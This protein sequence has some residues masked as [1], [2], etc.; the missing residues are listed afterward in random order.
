MKRFF[1]VASLLSPLLLSLNLSAC[2][3]SVGSEPELSA[4]RPTISPVDPVNPIPDPEKDP[5]A[6]DS[7]TPPV[8]K[9]DVL[10]YNGAGVDTS[11]WQNTEKLLARAGYTY[12]LVN[13]TE[14]NAMSLDELTRFRMFLIPGGYGGTIYRNI[15]ESA[16]L[17]IRRAVRE[18]GVGY[19][20]IC[21]GAWV[22]V[23]PEAGTWETAD[24][25]FAVARGRQ[26]ELFRDGGDNVS[27]QMV[28]FADGTSR[29]L[30]LWGGPITPSWSGGVVARYSTGDP[31][32]SQ[33]YAG[34][35]FV[36]VVGPHPEAP[37]DWRNE[38]GPDP[39]GLDYAVTYRLIDS[40]LNRVPL[41]TY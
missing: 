4:L 31:A 18:E 13:A 37:L 16:R 7:G 32:I 25:G 20:G 12:R 22:G 33:T 11:D 5:A 41:Q 28:T 17:R 29:S 38:T 10:L 9:T 15:S 6:G 3:K 1:Y 26:L 14:I 40:V 39:D 24:Y 23:G 2:G 21:A 27:M 35:G 30:V 8:K 36:I 19:L 34:S